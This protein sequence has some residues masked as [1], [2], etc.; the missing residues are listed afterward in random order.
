MNATTK[1]FNPSALDAGIAA[2]FGITKV[3][4][5]GD[6]LRDRMAAA[7]FAV[8]ASIQEAPVKFKTHSFYADTEFRDGAGKLLAVVCS[9]Q[10]HERMTSALRAALSAAPPSTL[11]L[12]LGRQS[13][14]Q[15]P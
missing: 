1:T 11:S 6:I 3:E 7:V 2:W 9:G 12:P 14:P 4:P 13:L 10:H 5:E 15:S 8:Q